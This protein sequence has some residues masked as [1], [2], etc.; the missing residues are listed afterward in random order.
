MV[1]RWIIRGLFMLPVLLC[2]GGWVWS[3]FYQAGIWY[4]HAEKGLAVCTESGIVEVDVGTWNGKLT[5][6]HYYVDRYPN[7]RLYPLDS[8]HRFLGFGCYQLDTDV[9]IDKSPSPL[10]WGVSIPYWFLV[11]ISAVLL[12]LVWR[13]TRPKPDPRTAFPVELAKR[14]ETP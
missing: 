9:G 10:L 13:K 12:W 1:R 11:F 7:A 2:V 5:G 14:S 4:W 3:G 6:R 8:H